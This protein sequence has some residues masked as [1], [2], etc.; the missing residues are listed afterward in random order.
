MNL[1]DTGF[2]IANIVQIKIMHT[3]NIYSRIKKTEKGILLRTVTVC[4]CMDVYIV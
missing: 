3:R 4:V 2:D 1:M